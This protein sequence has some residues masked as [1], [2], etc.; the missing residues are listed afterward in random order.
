MW[1]PYQILLPLLSL[2]IVRVDLTDLFP[3]RYDVELIRFFDADTALVKQGS[4]EFKVRLMSIDA[5][6]KGQ[7]FLGK[8][9]DAGA[10]ALRCL[11]MIIKGKK[12][13]ELKIFK[14]DIY[15]RALGELDQLS[16]ELVKNGCV[17]LYPYAEFGSRKQKWEFVRLLAQAKRNKAGLW[18]FGGY[19]QPKLWRKQSYRIGKP[20]APISKRSAHPQ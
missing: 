5:P 19:R 8:N 13:F 2:F 4:R 16:W 11:K 1:R 17:T 12:R 15:G 6:E 7:P 14:Q 10:E 18:A 3:L 20:S 9:G